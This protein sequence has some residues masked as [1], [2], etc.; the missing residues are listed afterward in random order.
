MKPRLFLDMD[1]VL[2]D[3][4]KATH[5]AHGR[6]DSY[7]EGSPFFPG[8]L[9]RF[10]IEKI[11]G[12]SAKEFWQA[13]DGPTFWEDIEPMPDADDIVAMVVE[14]FG[15]D[16]ICVLTSPSLSPYCIPGKKTWM[17]ANFPIFKNMLFGS[18]KQFLAYP[19]AV[20]IDDKDSNVEDFTSASGRGILLPRPWNSQYGF[21]NHT[22]VCL[23]H[24]L[25]GVT[26]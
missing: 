3:F 12:I 24:D 25:K 5:K 16:N 20:L 9:G 21:R 10:D 18:C 14:K 2:A 7:S 13:L 17:K 11:W 4:N 15:A 19:G 26:A 23:R 22:I 1:G 8:S 6:P